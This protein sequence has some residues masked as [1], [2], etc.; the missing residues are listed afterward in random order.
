[1]TRDG[2]CTACT[3]AAGWLSVEGKSCRELP[4]SGCSDEK[5]RGQPLGAELQVFVDEWGYRFGMLWMF[6]KHCRLHWTCRSA[7]LI[8]LLDVWRSFA[9]NRPKGRS[10]LPSLYYRTVVFPG[11][12]GSIHMTT[13]SMFVCS[14]GWA[15]SADSFIPAHPSKNPKP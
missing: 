4:A 6:G 11:V 5:V 7:V 3:S 8:Q 15:C 9:E 2:A 1:M 12:L 13:F 14:P 10:H